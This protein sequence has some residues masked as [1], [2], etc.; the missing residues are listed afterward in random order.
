MRAK[1][2]AEFEEEF[3]DDWWFVEDEHRGRSWRQRVWNAVMLCQGLEGLGMIRPELQDRWVE[4]A[5][6]WRGKIAALEREPGVVG[7]GRQATL[8]YPFLLGDLR[9]LAGGYVGGT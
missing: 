4:R 8:E 5:R 1:A 7:V 9:V 3:Q 2:G 6:E